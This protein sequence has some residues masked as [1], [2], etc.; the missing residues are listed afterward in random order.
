M[1]SEIAKLTRKAS[2]GFASALLALAPL[3]SAD[4]AAHYTTPAEA[5]ASTASVSV[6]LVSEDVA[7]AIAEYTQ[8]DPHAVARL[9]RLLGA[10]PDT[11]PLDFDELPPIRQLQW[12]YGALEMT[13]QGN[14]ER[15]V[16]AFIDAIAKETPGILTEPLVEAWL[17]RQ[18]RQQKTPFVFPAAR[19]KYVSVEIP[20]RVEAV[21]ALVADV[22][23]S[24]GSSFSARTIL[25]QHLGFSE[26]RVLLEILEAGSGRAAIVNALTTL[27]EPPQKRKLA[28]L[29]L[30][31]LRSLP[32]AR[33]NHVLNEAVFRWIGW[34][35]E[36]YGE[37]FRIR[38][39]MIGVAERGQIN[40]PPD[41]RREVMAV[42]ARIRADMARMPGLFLAKAES[43]RPKDVERMFYEYIAR[44]A[45]AAALW[46][47]VVIGMKDDFDFEPYVEQTAAEMRENFTSK[48]WLMKQLPETPKGR[49]LS[50]AELEEVAERM[51]EAAEDRDWEAQ[52]RKQGPKPYHGFIE[53][54][55][56]MGFGPVE[57]ASQYFQSDRV[58]E[59][60]MRICPTA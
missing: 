40:A 51:A 24:R 19:E 3:V 8:P 41:K 33:S 20:P 48:E 13:Q 35:D 50:K 59:A 58:A 46:G 47:Y 52:A 30:E 39:R 42:V 38:D 1:W 23:T 25:K 53:Y 6:P 57:P 14:G 44:N 29:S 54:V 27:S 9:V 17:A 2:L 34:D 56:L 31:I 11:L 26:E 15:F 12:A 28:Q 22:V 36:K 16:S 43:M 55:R 18:P 7:F 37:W 60:V 49:H 21:I 45:D 32:A 4:A 5:N 10:T